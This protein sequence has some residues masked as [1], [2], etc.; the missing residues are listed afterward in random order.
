VNSSFRAGL[1]AGF[2]AGAALAGFGV[3]LLRPISAP[4]AP[5]PVPPP[6]AADARATRLAEDKRPPAEQT[7][8]W[9][10]AKPSAP[11]PEP[12]ARKVVPPS[13]GIKERFEKL[14]ELGLT[15]LQSPDTA[16]LLKAV[17]ESGKPALEF[18]MNVLRSS[19]SASERFLAAALLEGAAD[20]S[21]VP[22]LA[23]ALKSDKDDI[24]RRMASHALAVLGA[25]EGE[26]ALRAASIGDADWGVR[27]NSAYGLAKLKQD[28]GLHLLQAA[29]E[30]SD[31]PG[32]YRL[33]IL[34][35]LA[36]VAAPSTAP[37]F[38]RILADSKDAG[39]LLTAIQALGKMKDA[40]ALPALQQISSSTQP[41]L[42][43]QAAARAV[44]SIQNG[45]GK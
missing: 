35:G 8:D 5:R 30:G 9:K 3:L 33:A 17:K 32:E 24:V 27:V 29:Y 7:V 15:A 37:L 25:S 6:L 10:V 44:Q 4:A 19:A 13:A 16:D 39:Y 31:T 1:V 23:E 28:D 2:I 36:D 20:P 43:K 22:A 12:E 42:V 21:S 34:G 18:L 11:T 14:V 45:A 40:D 38:R 26:G 41:D